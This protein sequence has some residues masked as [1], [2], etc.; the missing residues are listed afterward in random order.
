[1]SKAKAKES[2]EAKVSE[3]ELRD[4]LRELMKAQAAWNKELVDSTE[5][6]DSAA[7]QVAEAEASA[8]CRARG[9]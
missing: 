4:E 6:R 9:H 8:R 2:K 3:D 7:A 1:M 5:D